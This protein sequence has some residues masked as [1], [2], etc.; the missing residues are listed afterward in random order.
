[1]SPGGPP[2]DGSPGFALSSARRVKACPLLASLSVQVRIPGDPAS[3]LLPKRIG[4]I[5]ALT[6]TW[7]T[8]GPLR[9]SRAWREG[10]GRETAT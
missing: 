1:M 3:T 7:P 9:E 10:S 4:M 6:K 2:D 5:A 8:F